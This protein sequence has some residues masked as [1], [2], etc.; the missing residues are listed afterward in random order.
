MPHIIYVQPNKEGILE[1][2]NTMGIVHGCKTLGVSHF[3]PVST[4]DSEKGKFF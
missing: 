4:W 1:D 3:I 2:W